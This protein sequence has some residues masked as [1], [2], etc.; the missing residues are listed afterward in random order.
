MQRMS[1][2]GSRLPVRGLHTLKLRIRPMQREAPRAGLGTT[3][4]T[5]HIRRIWAAAVL[6]VFVIYDFIQSS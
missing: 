3:E 1:G 2:E 5:A 4:N 6:S